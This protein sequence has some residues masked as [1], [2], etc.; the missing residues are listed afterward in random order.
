MKRSHRKLCLCNQ[1][2]IQSITKDLVYEA[3]GETQ[4][5]FY[6]PIAYKGLWVHMWVVNVLR[7]DRYVDNKHE[8]HFFS[9]YENGVLVNPDKDER[10]SNVYKARFCGKPWV[11]CYFLYHMQLISFIVDS[12]L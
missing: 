11:E 1:P 8:R 3:Y 2:F 6:E 10:F 7:S 9:I 12:K 4:H 5:V